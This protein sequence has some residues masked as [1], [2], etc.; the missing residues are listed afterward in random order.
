MRP[1]DCA[2]VRG[3][4][5]PSAAFRHS[6]PGLNGARGFPRGPGADARA[7][8]HCVVS[9]R[10]V[11]GSAALRGR[12]PTPRAFRQAS[13][14]GD[15]AGRGRPRA[16]PGAAQA[17]CVLRP[18]GAASGLRGQSPAQFAWGLGWGPGPSG[19]GA[20]WAGGR[21][22]VRSRGGWGD[23]LLSGDGQS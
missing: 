6:E 16:E 5:E 1:R 3:R 13:C 14:C 4:P 10:R 15:A 8:R 20:A 19:P 11:A 2:S 7:P 18:W 22:Q 12:N 23:Y 9:A 17:E 21:R